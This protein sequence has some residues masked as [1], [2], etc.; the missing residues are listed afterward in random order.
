MASKKDKEKID[1]LYVASTTES[2]SSIVPY[3]PPIILPPIY[4][5]LLTVQHLFSIEK[6]HSQDKSPRELALSYLPRDFHWIPE[7]LQKN[8]DYYTNILFQSESIRFHPIYSKSSD[9]LIVRG[10]IAYFV[11]FIH[12]KD[13]GL[14]P[15]T[16]RPFAGSAIPYSYYDYINAWFRFML[17]QTPEFTHCWIIN[18]DKNFD[19]A[20]PIWF[21]QWWKCFGLNPDTLPPQLIESFHLFTALKSF[22]SDFPPILHF[23]KKYK[24]PWFMRW[25]YVKREGKIER[26]WYQTKLKEKSSKIDAIVKNVNEMAQ[27][28][29]MAQTSEASTSFQI[30]PYSAFSRYSKG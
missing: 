20:I 19:G 4:V 3:I 24:I 22:D 29:Q 13:W 11:K 5:P 6:N 27:L 12:E 16:L 10:T 25:K 30:S 17:L 15:S 18:F 28:A 14:H 2:S 1:M 21:L 23:V 9:S 26:H 8:L 7:D